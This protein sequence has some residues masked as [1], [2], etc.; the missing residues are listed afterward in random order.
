M[1]AEPILNRETRGQTPL[2]PNLSPIWGQTVSWPDLEIQANKSID[3]LFFYSL[4]HN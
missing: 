1:E 4:G 2:H 3:S